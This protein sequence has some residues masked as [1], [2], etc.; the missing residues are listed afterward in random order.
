MS[1]KIVGTCALCK[2]QNIIL[3]DSHIIPKFVSRRLIK[4]SITGFLRQASNPNKRLQDGDSTYLLC[5]D[6]EQKFSKY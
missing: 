3:Q 4:K 6:C 5:A 2:S 1:A